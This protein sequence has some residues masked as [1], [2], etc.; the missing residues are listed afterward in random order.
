MIVYL[1]GKPEDHE[2]FNEYASDLQSRGIKVVSTWHKSGALAELLE[3]W[4]QWIA[5]TKNS[6]KLFLANP[7]LNSEQAVSSAKADF[8]IELY[9]CL[10]NCKGEIELAD[11]VIADLDGGSMEA[12]LAIA[13]KKRVIT[14]GTVRSPFS[15]VYNEEAKAVE[16]WTQV[17]AKLRS[18]RGGNSFVELLRE[19]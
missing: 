4:R 3:Q 17:L 11:C 19:F 1:A 12:G 15:V 9:A 7:K 6:A 5:R 16:G 8:N 10:E 13:S 2:R 18:V 14:M